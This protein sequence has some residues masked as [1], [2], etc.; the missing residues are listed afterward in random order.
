M[1]NVVLLG[2]IAGTLA[3]A[4]CPT[5][6]DCNT[7]T[8]LA[9]CYF[10]NESIPAVPYYIYSVKIFLGTF[11]TLTKKTFNSIAK[12]HILDLFIT[13][14]IKIEHVNADAF[15]DL[16]YL[17]SL[18]LSGNI[19]DINSLKVSLL[20]LTNRQFSLLRF[21]SMGWTDM[22]I[23]LFSGAPQNIGEVDMSHNEQI[24]VSNGM[25]DGLEKLSYLRF[26][27]NSMVK[28]SES[29][30]QLISLLRLDLSGNRIATC[31]ID[32]LPVTLKELD[33]AANLLTRIPNFCSS[34]GS[35][36]MPSLKYL[37]L[38]NNI[39][40]FIINDTLSCLTSLITIDLH[41]NSIP[42]VPSN[43]LPQNLKELHLGSNRITSIQ[44]FCSSN[45]NGTSILPFLRIL[46][47][48]D[49][50]IDHLGF[51]TFDCLPSLKT[52]NV[53]R[54]FLHL[55][56]S[57]TFNSLTKLD[58]LDIS[59]LKD[60]TVTDR[61]VLWD[62]FDNPSL[63]HFSSMG[64]LFFP[65][66][67]NC[68]SLESIDISGSNLQ[69]QPN[70]PLVEQHFG[71]LLHLK[72]LNVSYC[73]L[74][75]IPQDFLKPFPNVEKVFLNDNN[76]KELNA[77]LF[78]ENSKIKILSL[79]SNLVTNIENKTFSPAFWQRVE[80]VDLSGNPFICDCNFLWFRDKFKSSQQTLKPHFLQ[81]PGVSYEC[82]APAERIGLQVSNF[83]LTANECKSKKTKSELLSVILSVLSICAIILI[84]VLVA[85]RGRWHIR[86]WIYLIRYK[87]KYCKKFN[88][89]AFRYDA[90]VI[91]GD[92]DRKFVHNTLLPKL[93]DEE[94]LRLCVHFRDFE[95]GKIIS[96][97]IVECMG[98]SRMAIVILS[99]YFCESRWCKFELT[100][101]QDRWLNH[102]SDALLIVMLEEIQ[103]EN[104][105]NELRALI[106]TTTYAMW[107]DDNQGQRLFWDKILNALRRQM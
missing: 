17:T 60:R 31:N 94:Q 100:I 29:F 3:Y 41:A 54:N 81:R 69:L 75:R 85:Y 104:M 61:I 45:G 27:H 5:E 53:A 48:E 93:E 50:R 68:P 40:H 13:S 52:L 102:E 56:G 90:F 8:H 42:N 66:L 7:T 36:I 57:Q 43:F 12:N 89:N 98:N 71:R 92:D 16:I 46:S 28:C 35:S 79:A 82:N 55:I 32:F 76:I 19:I 18:D 30:K 63:K 88:D 97:N 9:S 25:F 47:L 49:N 84:S 26:A 51:R 80:E 14:F 87:R 101:A 78:Y 70:L 2:F 107:T 95:P 34:N 33:L 64:N 86:Y 96:D 72:I 59:N 22:S 15:E 77:S 37:Y 67:S 4:P 23:R 24:T 10:I 62:A 65:N 58:I 103:S 99:R 38:E 105:T 21:Q 83:T 20:S 106:R 73:Q 6:C 1:I 11:S 91:Y 44:D 74:S 39:I